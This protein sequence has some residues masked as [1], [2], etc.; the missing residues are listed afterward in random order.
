MLDGFFYAL[1]LFGVLQSIE[2]KRATTNIKSGG[3]REFSY[4]VGIQEG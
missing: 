2:E 1:R 4:W 3:Y